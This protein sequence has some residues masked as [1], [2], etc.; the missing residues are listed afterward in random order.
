M[1]QL[2][3][4][5][6]LTLKTLNLHYQKWWKEKKNKKTTKAKLKSSKIASGKPAGLILSLFFYDN[7]TQ[8]FTYSNTVT[9]AVSGPNQ[10]KETDIVSWLLSFHI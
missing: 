5:F 1:V 10:C 2:L 4:W 8:W 9:R 7:E 3:L 6:Q